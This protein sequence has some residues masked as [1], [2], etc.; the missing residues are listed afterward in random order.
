MD[1]CPRD[2]EVLTHKRRSLRNVITDL[3]LIII[4]KVRDRCRVHSVQI[5]AKLR[6]FE[7]HRLG[8]RISGP[9]TDS[10]QRAVYAAAAIEP[11]GRRIDHRLI[12]IIVTVPF[13]LLARNPRMRMNGID[14]SGNRARDNR[15]VVIHAIAHGITGTNLDRNSILPL[16][17]HQLQAKW[18]NIAIDIRSCNILQMAAGTDPLL[19]TITNHG[20]IMLH[21]LLA[22][23]LQF[24][25]N[26]IIRAGDQNSGFLHP[27]L[28]NKTEI[29]MTCT[30]P[31]GNLR[32]LI[33]PFHAFVYRITVLLAV[34]EELAGLN[35]A[36]RPAKAMKLIIDMDDLIRRIRCPR[37]LT[38]TEGGI[39]DPDILRH[40]L[41]HGPV[42]ERN[43]RNVRIRKHLTEHI[44]L[45]HIIQNVHVL[46]DL[47]QMI[48]FIH[49]DRT[50]FKRLC[51]HTILLW[52]S[53]KIF[54]NS[55][56]YNCIHLIHLRQDRINAGK[57]GSLSESPSVLR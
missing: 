45:L 42:I 51:N 36:V 21:G 24:Q 5:T 3:L 52:M 11:C 28:M 23:H 13:Q 8:R 39:G 37:L 46:F 6:I 35:H 47:K 4:R 25:E 43:L 10:E 41:R 56:M 2:I 54:E 26:M 18:H 16:Q 29:I 14:N 33:S 15:T 57:R 32:E 55:S 9:L 31:A 53:Y 50:I 27:H 38:I 12:E 40:A 49:R 48:V 44:R 30:N 1:T 34:Q 20:K 19:Q 17:L 22:G 7:N